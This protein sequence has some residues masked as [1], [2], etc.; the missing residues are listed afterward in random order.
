MEPG[1][2][3]P[4]RATRYAPAMPGGP[5]IGRVDAI[6]PIPGADLVRR[7]VVSLGDHTLQVVFG[8]RPVVEP[9]SLVPV[10]P[11]GS[12]VARQGVHRVVKMRTRRYRATISQGMLCSLEELGWVTVGPDEV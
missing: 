11:P 12:R 1:L 8:G 3:T 10:A 4:W 5:V 6:Q 9:Y 7:A 2:Q